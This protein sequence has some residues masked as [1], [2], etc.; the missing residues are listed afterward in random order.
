LSVP[1]WLAL[2][3]FRRDGW[4]CIHCHCSN[5]L[6]PHHIT[7]KS[8][9]GLDEL[10]NLATLCMNCHR[11]VHDGKLVVYIYVPE[12]VCR[13]NITMRRKQ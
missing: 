5:N 7:F 10:R 2:E 3:C 6:H 13:D 1:K 4:R 11:D 8:Q 12:D 9:G